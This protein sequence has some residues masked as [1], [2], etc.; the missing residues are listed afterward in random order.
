MG[1]DLNQNDDISL[2]IGSNPALYCIAI[3]TDLG[4]RYVKSMKNGFGTCKAGAHSVAR[5]L[6]EAILYGSENKDLER[7]LKAI[8]L[9]KWKEVKVIK[10]G[11]VS[12]T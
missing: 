4:W 8:E 7:D 2:L 1:D 9:Q 6:S 10:L 5:E 12:T 11:V 3:L